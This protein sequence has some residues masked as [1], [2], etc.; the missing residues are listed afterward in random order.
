MRN[1]VPVTLEDTRRNSEIFQKE[2]LLSI[3]V[4]HVMVEMGK[5]KVEVDDL[6]DLVAMVKQDQVYCQRAKET[7]DVIYSSEL[8][9]NMA[10]DEWIARNGWQEG[11]FIV[12]PSEN[13]AGFDLVS[14]R[15]R[16]GSPLFL[17]SHVCQEGAKLEAQL[18][19]DK[20]YY[21]SSRIWRV[22]VFMKGR[23]D[24]LE[25]FCCG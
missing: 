8:D 25:G 15:I 18:V 11:I 5:S 20:A 10:G 3:A 24:D 4:R 6:E 16:S 23:A 21:Y 7:L 9:W 14:N 1:G 13:A 19:K 12:R 2:V 22:L 17:S